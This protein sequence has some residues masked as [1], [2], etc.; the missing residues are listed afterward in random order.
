M[1]LTV[2]LLIALIIGT[3]TTTAS[4]K[5]TIKRNWI[6][7][8]TIKNGTPG[9]TIH[10][11]VDLTDVKNKLVMCQV[12]FY[13]SPGGWSLRDKN[14][15][16]RLSPSLNYVAAFEYL[17]PTQANMSADD[18]AV[19]IP[20]EELH[21]KGKHKY[22]IYAQVTL[23]ANPGKDGEFLAESDF[24]P[25]IIDLTDNDNIKALPDNSAPVPVA[26][27]KEYAKNNKGKKAMVPVDK[28]VK[29]DKSDKKK[30]DKKKKEKKKRRKGDQ[31][32]SATIRTHNSNFRKEAIDPATFWEKEEVDSASLPRLYIE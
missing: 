28:K 14:N 8:G 26:E 24:Y 12:M 13:S 20:L 9:L 21:L 30:D 10:T 15:Q 19:Y 1:R 27:A 7:T 11:A 23:L 29:K 5:A 4:S 3:A 25:V 32:D 16:Y 6:E 18:I 22:R 31:G 17:R 2:T